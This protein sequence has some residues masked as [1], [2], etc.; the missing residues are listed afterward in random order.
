M[1]KA[2]TTQSTP[3][4]R[5][6]T[7]SYVIPDTIPA[8]LDF[9]K[10]KVQDVELVLFESPEKSSIPSVPEIQ[11]MQGLAR[12]WDLTY[13][14]HLPL[15]L[16]AGAPDEDTR[17]SAVENWIRVLKRTESLSPVGWVV[18]LNQPHPPQTREGET[19]KKQCQK[20]ILELSRVVPPASLCIENLTYS[21]EWIWPWVLDM[22]CSLC[23]DIGHLLLM[24]EDVEAVC[25]TWLPWTRIIHLHALNPEGHDH[26]GLQHMDTSFLA[27]L[28]QRFDSATGPSRVVTLEIFSRRNF[29]ASLQALQEA[30]QCSTE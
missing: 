19:W 9:L 8:N 5:L 6:G 13:T 4:W 23:M 10:D 29:E 3:H 26:K 7:T 27:R 28:L 14:V 20:S 16:E 1:T 11:N 2:N 18:H 12:E 15:D 17:R 22:G 21:H 24:G 30:R 25:D